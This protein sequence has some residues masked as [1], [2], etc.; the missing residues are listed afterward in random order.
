M[1]NL[2]IQEEDYFFDPINSIDNERILELRLAL[3]YY[4]ELFEK[5]RKSN[6]V[7]VGN[8]LGFYGHIEHFCIDK[9]AT[10]P[11]ISPAGEVHN[12]DAIDYNYHGKDVI[13][14]STIEHIGLDDYGNKEAND[15]L[16]AITA[17]NK[18][19]EESDSYFITF[20]TNHN[21]TLDKYIVDNIDQYKWHGWCRTD[22][23]KWEY[24]KQDMSVWEKVHDTPFKYANGIILLT[25]EE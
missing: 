6:I 2:N 15:G 18:I 22:L 3:D 19:K 11:D 5:G 16:D 8:V 14:I 25:S 9:F 23:N 10:I 4:Q 12:I 17:L 7:E 1:I 24:T 20:G 21:K 13:S